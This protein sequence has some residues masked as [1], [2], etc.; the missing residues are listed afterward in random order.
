[1]RRTLLLLAALPFFACSADDVAVTPD[2]GGVDASKD[3]TLDT[4]TDAPGPVDAAKDAVLDAPADAV[5]DASV[6][7]PVDASADVAIDAPADAASDAKVDA[8]GSGWKSPTC[9]GTISANEYGPAQNQ[10]TTAGGQVWYQTWDATNLYVALTNAN[11]TEATVLYVGHSGAGLMSGQIYDATAPG[12]LIFKADAVVYAKDGYNEVRKVVSSAWGAAT[13]SAITF[14]KGGSTTRE[15]VIPWAA[16]GANVIPSSFRWVGY[17]TSSSG[18]VY[19]QVPETNPAGAI[20]T[21]ATFAHDYYV[22]STANGGGA[23]PFATV[24]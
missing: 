8:G 1:M 23:F 18:F 7:A 20:G 15:L 12:S 22:S 10:F 9:D 3:V 17:T 11:V 16:L 19:A 14:C 6:D 5:A 13:A 4:K 21:N 2:A 24:E